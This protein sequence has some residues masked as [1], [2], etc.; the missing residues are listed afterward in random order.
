MKE[1]VIIINT[2][3]GSVIDIHA[4]LQA[5]AQNKVAAAGLDVLPE[6]PAIREEAELLRSI[7]HKKYNLETLLVDHILLRLRNVYIT[8][9][10][11]FYT[12]E[13]IQRILDTTVDNINAFVQGRTQNVV[14]GK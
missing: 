14:S 7:Y 4:L 13:A 5:L 6:E 12:R 8:P 9:H 10:S 2:S 1:G 11:A 3:R